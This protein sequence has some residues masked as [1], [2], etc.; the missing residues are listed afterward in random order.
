LI[1]VLK[2]RLHNSYIRTNSLFADMEWFKAWFDSPYYH[3]LYGNRN[4]DEAKYFLDN[5]LKHFS[6]DKKTKILD[7]GCGRGRHAIY[8]HRKGFDVTGFDLSPANIEH[9]KKAECRT[10]HFFVHDLRNCFRENHFGIVLNLFSSFG[11]FE[12]ETENKEAMDALSRS[13][14][15]GGLLIVDF[16]NPDFAKK[17]LVQTETVKVRNIVFNIE[18]S[19]KEN[20]I[21]KKILVNDAGKQQK[22][23]ERIMA[24]SK[25]DFEKY[26]SAAGLKLKTIFGSYELEPFSPDTSERMIMIAEKI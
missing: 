20:F 26:F 22:F 13:L 18:R 10:L 23:M 16:L 19:T 9:N 5:L 2:Q 3:I 12:N 25:S 21:T 1:N 15:K 7:A 8:L 6:F 4:E 14:Q 17:N 11:Y 24:I